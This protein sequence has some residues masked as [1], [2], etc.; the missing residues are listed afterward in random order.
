MASQDSS[1]QNPKWFG[2]ELN[3]AFV[4][5]KAGLDDI[6]SLLLTWMI[7]VT[8]LP[9][10]YFF[11]FLHSLNEIKIHHSKNL[12]YG[13]GRI[14]STHRIKMHSM[15][16]FICQ[17]VTNMQSTIYKNLTKTGLL[18]KRNIFENRFLPWNN[19][20]SYQYFWQSFAGK[21]NSA[22]DMKFAVWT[23][24]FVTHH[25]KHQHVP[26]NFSDVENRLLTIL[27]IYR[28]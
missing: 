27:D 20:S 1:R 28:I 17:E 12:F 18:Q 9:K 4:A 2:S 23:R 8:W 14:Q 22:T 11:F 7:S 21:S 25:T 5:H 10:C 26:T 15:F 3:G 16:V 19:R 6:L 24:D 13:G